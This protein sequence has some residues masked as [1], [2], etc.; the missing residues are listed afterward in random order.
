MLLNA[1]DT[2]LGILA[3]IIFCAAYVLVV[4]EEFTQLRKSKPVI[5]ASGLIWLLVA[6]I[7]ARSNLSLAAESAVKHNIQ[8]YGELFLFL[9]VA[10]TYVNVMQERKVFDSLRNWLVNRNF[11]FKQLFWLTG[12]LAF[13]ISPLV[14][15][16]TT[17][18]I[19]CA[20]IIA[21]GKDNKN[22]IGLSCINIVIA[23]NAGGVYSPF[24]DITTLMVWQSGKLSTLEFFN[25]FIPAAV[26]YLLPA[27]IMS[28]Y[29]SKG[30]PSVAHE[31]IKIAQGGKAIIFLF[32]LT[33][34]TAISFRAILNLPPVIGMMT[35]LAYLQFYSYY[36]KISR[37]KMHFSSD[38]A[39]QHDS[40]DIIKKVEE[41]E[42]D[43][44]LF[45]YGIML[46]VGG[47]AA[48]GFL[49]YL[50]QLL[51]QDLLWNL[52]AA[53]QATPANVILGLVSAVID[54]IPVVYAVLSMDPVMSQGQ[55]LLITLTSGIGGSLLSVGSA[56]G[57]ALMG[58]ARQHYTFF[59]HLKSLR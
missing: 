36:L 1:I 16:L 9:L 12:L 58:Q 54:N 39:G 10:M 4:S 35:G 45:F 28:F 50:S 5:L 53:Q 44:L 48:L 3:L 17:A 22:F 13:L 26:S 38:L 47:L 21:V 20:V 46:C 2:P 34:L 18:L 37:Q 52:P 6:I 8:E 40:F 11:N 55:W 56:A 19:M 29:I 15:N 7:A 25:I 24:G 27:L 43:T 23:A 57:V 33:I 30:M 51:Y 31:K 32:A 42:W 41:I 49:N 59:T 14:D